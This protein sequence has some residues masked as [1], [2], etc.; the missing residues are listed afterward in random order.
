MF[1]SIS[2]LAVNFATGCVCIWTRLCTKT[3]YQNQRILLPLPR[4]LLAWALQ[5]LNL[6]SIRETIQI[7]TTGITGLQ[8]NRKYSACTIKWRQPEKP[9]DQ[10]LIFAQTCMADMIYQPLTRQLKFLNL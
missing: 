6:T 4:K 10:T 7:N 1:P 9:L 3:N 2:C 5:Q 8:A